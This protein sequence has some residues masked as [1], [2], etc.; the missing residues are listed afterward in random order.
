MFANRQKN[1]HTDPRQHGN[2]LETTQNTL[3]IIVTFQSTQTTTQKCLN[4][5]Q[6]YNDHQATT[7]SHRVTN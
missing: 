5:P 3:V 6:Q 1:K 7:Y 4:Q 2:A